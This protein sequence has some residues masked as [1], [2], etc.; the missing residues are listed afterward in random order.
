MTVHIADS[1]QYIPRLM[2]LSVPKITLGRMNAQSITDQIY[3]KFL[4]MKLSN[5][6]YYSVRNNFDSLN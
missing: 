5:K 6:L 3:L 2:A 4:D 1:V